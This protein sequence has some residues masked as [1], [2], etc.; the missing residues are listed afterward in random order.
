M[1]LQQIGGARTL[2]T[3]MELVHGN[4]RNPKLLKLQTRE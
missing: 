3:A 1:N 4:Q 2:G